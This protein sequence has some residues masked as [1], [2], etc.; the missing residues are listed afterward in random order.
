MPDLELQHRIRLALS[1]R[2]EAR[3]LDQEARARF[4][5]GTL[6]EGRF[7]HLQQRFAA[8]E[9]AAQQAL[10]AIRLREARTAAKLGAH[11]RDCLGRRNAI[12]QQIKEGTV[13][14]ATATAEL[15]RLDPEIHALRESV[16]EFNT[17]LAAEDPEDVGG[18]VAARLEEY[19][20]RIAAMTEAL[21]TPVT[22]PVAETMFGRFRFTRAQ[23]RVG[24]VVL[25]F[26]LVGAV[27]LAFVLSSSE[28]ATLELH[29]D[30]AQPAELQVTLINRGTH[31]LMVYVPEPEPGAMR[32]A[33][34]AALLLFHADAQGTLQPLVSGSA[35][36][37]E[38]RSTVY[39]NPQR[40]TVGA[41]ARLLLRLDQVVPALP[42]GLQSI[43]VRC[44]GPSGR[45]LQ[46]QRVTVTVPS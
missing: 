31:E 26:L 3:R 12:G 22:E 1:W 9:Q 35:W 6:E 42:P 20:L 8:E 38:G 28:A 39:S 15:E 14:H 44:V 11:L 18:A 13:S 40:L 16:A 37:S 46:R 5:A 7:R 21:A 10:E 29:W 23:M 27:S 24:A 43:E 32:Q 25:G 4:A 41:R 17:V 19:P 2:A 36:S 33:T 30:E 45:V 34:A